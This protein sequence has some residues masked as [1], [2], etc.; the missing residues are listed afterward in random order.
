M[1]STPLVNLLF[2]SSLPTSG[3]QFAQHEAAA[4]AA[5]VSRILAAQ[6]ADST[7]GPSVTLVE[8][9]PEKTLYLVT[10]PGHFAHPSI[11]KR[12]LV[13]SDQGRHIEVSG[14]TAGEPAPMAAWMAQFE[15][16][17][18]QMRNAALR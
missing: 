14:Y 17:D 18:A 4:R 10:Q 8:V 12:A 2:G 9:E 6:G 15:E 1:K 13:A 7:D 5:M 16:Q 11:L 3:Y